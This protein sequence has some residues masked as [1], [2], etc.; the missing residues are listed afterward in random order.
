[1]PPP[2]IERRRCGC[3]S[4][5]GGC[6]PTSSAPTRRPRPSR[7]TAA[8]RRPAQPR[9]SCDRTRDAAVR[10]LRPAR[11]E[12]TGIRTG[13][14]WK[15]AALVVAAL[16][17]AGSSRDHAYRGQRRRRRCAD[18]PA[19]Q[20]RQDRAADDESQ[21]R[22]CRSGMRPISSSSP[23]ATSGSRA[24][25]ARRRR[26]R[27]RNAGD[28]TLTRR[29]IKRQSRRRRWRARTLRVHRRPSGD[30]WVAN[31][32]PARGHTQDVVRI[33]A[34]TLTFEGRDRPGRARVLPRSGLRRRLALGRT[35]LRR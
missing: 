1:M 34:P 29:P 10:D 4:G 27:M 12:T 7:S 9:G 28:R 24:T 14:R 35:D 18:G 22:S 15:R 3:T 8:S 31:C 33:D 25:S 5:A 19:Q 20:R 32:Y 17:V 2:A 30:V 21:H 6:S 23:A 13:R 16:L 11:L 26:E